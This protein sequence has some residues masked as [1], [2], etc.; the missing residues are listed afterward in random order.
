MR[1]SS[2]LLAVILC[3]VGGVGEASIEVSSQKFPLFYLGLSGSFERMSGKRSEYFRE[4]DLLGGAVTQYTQGKRMS[5][6]N[7]AT[8]VL[9]GA[10][11]RFS[12]LPIAIGSEVYFGKSNTLSKIADVRQDNNIP[13]VNIYYSAGIQRKLYYGALL[14]VGYEFYQDYLASFLVGVERGQ[15]EVSKALT[16]DPENTSAILR[17]K[18]KWAS[19]LVLGVNLEKKIGDFNVG[20]DLKHIQYNRC[21][22]IDT[23]EDPLLGSSVLELSSRPQVFST[24][25]RISYLF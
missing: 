21:S 14:K 5:E 16:Y 25:L 12:P 8:S 22:F 18:T 13:P 17:G 10:L 3:T 15:F 2:Y 7:V 9:A 23:I 4:S 20:L 11:G 19:G 1:Y 24:A 6:N